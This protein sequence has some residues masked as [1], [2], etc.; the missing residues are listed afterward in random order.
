MMLIQIYFFQLFRAL[1]FESLVSTCV[2][3]ENY[4]AFFFIALIFFKKGVIFI[5]KS[6]FVFVKIFLGVSESC[7][8]IQFLEPP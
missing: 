8:M 3:T 2:D 6:S 5:F 7:M 4:F 1:F